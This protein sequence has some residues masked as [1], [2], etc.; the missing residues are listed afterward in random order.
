MHPSSQQT[1]YMLSEGAREEK[2]SAQCWGITGDWKRLD[3]RREACLQC[4]FNLTKAFLCISVVGNV[5]QKGLTKLAG[6]IY[7]M[8]L[9]TVNLKNNNL[10]LKK[11][12]L[13]AQHRLKCN[14]NSFCGI[15]SLRLIIIIM[16]FF[17]PSPF[18]ITQTNNF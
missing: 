3:A 1:Q 5:L 14:A 10:C 2:S 11:I 13:C 17:S 18:F 9:S 4:W 15:L 8:L 7:S 12:T 16:S 6:L